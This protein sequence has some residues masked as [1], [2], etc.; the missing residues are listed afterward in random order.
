MALDQQ[1][2]AD[3]FF[4]LVENPNEPVVGF[5]GQVD[6]TQYLI[7]DQILINGTAEDP[8]GIE[9][10]QY[11][12]DDE[13]EPIYSGMAPILLDSGSLSLGAHTVTLLA[14]N[15]LGVQN[16]T[17]DPASVLEF[18][19][20]AVPSG[21]P[22]AAPDISDISHPTEGMVTIT[23]TTVANAKVDITNIDLGITITAYANTGGNFTGQ[24][25]GDAGHQISVVVYDL[26]SSQDPSTVTTVAVPAAPVLT[27]ITVSPLTLSFET[28]GSYTDLSVTGHYESGTAADLTGQAVFSSADP[29]VAS[30]SPSGRVAAQAYGSTT[31]TAAF[32]GLSAQAAVDCNIVNLTAISVSPA[33]IALVSIGQTETLSVTGHYSDGSQAILAAGLAYITGNPAVATVNSAGIVTAAGNGATQVNVSCPGVPAVAIPVSVNT[34]L[35]PAPTIAILSP[36][37]GANV[38]RGDTVT[39]TVQ[40]NDDIGGVSRIYLET[41]G[42]T[43]HTDNRQIAPPSTSVTQGFTF[44]SFRFGSHWRYDNR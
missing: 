27:M 22:P 36:A 16:N 25:P 39:V 8:V 9:F 17:G 41:T 4:T 29:A 43:V 1:G 42:E 40:A 37:D 44:A 33:P 18:T 30:V 38:E 24:I 2:S 3:Y 21:P 15:N 26:S 10:M 19:I 23:G 11:Y 31:I 6:G 35:D 20:V 7:G 12:L 28:A 5:T 14:T 13:T 32:G 34:G